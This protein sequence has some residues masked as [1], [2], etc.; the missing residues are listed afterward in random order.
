MAKEAQCKYIVEKII[1]L[2]CKGIE[3]RFNEHMGETVVEWQRGKDK[4]WSHAHVFFFNG[5]KGAIA[6]LA[7][8]LDEVEK[9]T[10]D[11]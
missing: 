5:E 1:E 4:V 9:T 7:Q 2:S 10:S 11:R 8:I 6:S 3:L